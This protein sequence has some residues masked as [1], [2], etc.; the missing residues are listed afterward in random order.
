MDWEEVEVANEQ[1]YH[2]T[3]NSQFETGRLYLSICRGY[4]RVKTSNPLPQNEILDQGASPFSFRTKF[5]MKQISKYNV[6]LA[7][8]I[9][10][11]AGLP[12]HRQNDRRLIKELKKVSSPLIHA[13]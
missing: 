11:F 9:D 13:N 10:K 6:N 2:H 5:R 12:A 7:K 8:V 1:S 4:L 3:Q